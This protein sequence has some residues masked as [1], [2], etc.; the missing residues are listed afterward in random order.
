MPAPTNTT[1]TY[2]LRPKINDTAKANLPAESTE[3]PLELSFASQSIIE[4]EVYVEAEA[5]YAL[6]ANAG[7]AVAA[8]D[9]KGFILPAGSVRSFF[10]SPGETRKIY[11]R[12]TA[13][14]AVS[15]GV[16]VCYYEKP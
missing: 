3:T 16:S 12:A 2:G 11:I 1:E 4:I 6:A 5:E 8:L 10:N 14:T 9:A 15:G 7:A 13:D